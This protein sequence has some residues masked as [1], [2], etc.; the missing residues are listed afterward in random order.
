MLRPHP[1]I[2]GRAPRVAAATPAPSG[3]PAAEPKAPHDA[4]INE[5]AAPTAIEPPP[6]LDEAAPKDG[7]VTVT[8]LAVADLQS[9]R[10]AEDEDI[11]TIASEGADSP[12]PPPA[13]HGASDD[14]L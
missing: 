2:E 1:T 8:E 9:F 12:E 3:P 6:A 4:P 14:I 10:E 11:E 5:A 7:P 13:L